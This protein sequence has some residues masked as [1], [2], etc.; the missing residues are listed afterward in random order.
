[1][2]V[3]NVWSIAFIGNS[4]RQVLPFL[5]MTIAFLQMLENVI[6]DKRFELYHA[7]ETEYLKRL[8]NTPYA[9][10]SALS[11]I[12]QYAAS[13]H[14]IYSMLLRETG[15]SQKQMSLYG[16]RTRP[17]PVKVDNYK[18]LVTEDD[19]VTEL[20][21]K[22]Y[23][24]E[25]T[26]QIDKWVDFY[27]SVLA[28]VNHAIDPK[29]NPGFDPK[30]P[31]TDRGP[32]Q[33]VRVEYKQ[34]R[35][36]IM[37]GMSMPRPLVNVNPEYDERDVLDIVYEGHPVGMYLNGYIFFA[38]PEKGGVYWIE[39]K[40]TSLIGETISPT[41]V[42]SSH[43]LNLSTVDGPTPT[44]AGQRA[45]VEGKTQVSSQRNRNPTSAITEIVGLFTN[46]IPEHIT[47]FLP[48]GD[49]QKS[50]SQHVRE[51]YR[52]EVYRTLLT[53]H[54]WDH[55]AEEIDETLSKMNVFLHQDML[56]NMMNALI[57]CFVHSNEGYVYQA[58]RHNQ[59]YAMDTNYENA[60]FLFK[61][62]DNYRVVLFKG[63]T[64]TTRIDDRMR[65]FIKTS[66]LG[67]HEIPS[68]SYDDL[69]TLLGGDRGTERLKL[70]GQLFDTNGKCVGIRV[71]RPKQRGVEGSQELIMDLRISPQAP[72]MLSHREYIKS[73][74]ALQV[75]YSKDVR[76]NVD[77]KFGR[78]TDN[79]IDD[80]E[81]DDDSPRIKL[82]KRFKLIPQSHA[83]L[84]PQVG[85]RFPVTSIYEESR[86][87][88][89]RVYI[90]CRMVITHWL[91]FREDVRHGEIDEEWK[92]LTIRE[93]VDAY[94]RPSEEDRPS[95]GMIENVVMPEIHTNFFEFCAY[96]ERVY[97]NVFYTDAT[98][99]QAFHV[100]PSE[101]ERIR[102]YIERE[103][104][105][106]QTYPP[107]F[108]TQ[109]MNM[110]M[111][112]RLLP[113][114]TGSS[115]QTSDQMMERASSAD[116]G[117]VELIGDR[118]ISEDTRITH[119]KATLE[120]NNYYV[121]V[122]RFS[123]LMDPLYYT[124]TLGKIVKA[125][126]IMTEYCGKLYLLRLT[127]VIHFEVACFICEQWKK[128]RRIMSYE[129][130]RTART[131]S[132]QYVIH[133]DVISESG[134]N[135]DEEIAHSGQ[136]YRVLVYTRIEKIDETQPRVFKGKGSHERTEPKQ[137]YIAMLP[138][139]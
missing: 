26:K 117:V 12:S 37:V 49:D 58:P 78:F 28:H 65:N 13:K 89:Q 10:D 137:V 22:E 40:D 120:S 64:W 96:L 129:E 94:I 25:I 50:F 24:H 2:I 115:P 114:Y 31:Q 100:D 45:G 123:P 111:E 54:L 105:L 127:R 98:D 82:A 139:E 80:D 3:S 75:V 79:L 39:W 11:L 14:D 124:K 102:N 1:M 130:T 93:Y 43:Y 21:K 116:T 42:R 101:L 86:Q 19:K 56:Q 138:L 134:D 110:R 122:N 84:V 107:S 35:D 5:A 8:P 74:A 118:R 99:V 63:S 67:R 6:Y 57:F 38:Y 41:P 27:A 104:D 112:T 103:L 33:R 48:Q 62:K 59:W 83:S 69:G 128:H 36:L 4:H 136:D 15:L 46:V 113:T 95:R 88:K 66:L 32:N 135:N 53:Q 119:V 131:T 108:V 90:F 121:R 18:M 125:K 70:D 17:F 85:V 126:L 72:I 34:L 61:T 20:A 87:W 60:M 16:D 51:S 52:P 76:T 29:S 77:K 9:H 92:S 109:F 132:R 23:N 55:T 73:M 68:I 106:I 30:N 71:V 133:R 81:N 97:A 44:R 47:F 91:L 7:H